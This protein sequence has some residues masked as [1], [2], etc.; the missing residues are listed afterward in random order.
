MLQKE[1]QL[2]Q[3]DPVQRRAMAEELTMILPSVRTKLAARNIPLDF[4]Y[5][6]IYPIWQPDTFHIELLP[7][8]I[9]WVMTQA[10]SDDVQLAQNGLRDDRKHILKA[11][12]AGIKSIQR[13]HILYRQWPAAL[14][15]Q[16]A[17]TSIVVPGIKS[18]QKTDTIL[19]DHPSQYALFKFLA[20]KKLME[21]DLQKWGS[22]EGFV[23]WEYPYGTGQALPDIAQELSISPDRLQ[24]F[25]AWRLDS[26]L[27]DPILVP[28]PLNRY[29][30]TKAFI[31]FLHQDPEEEA[32]LAY[33]IVAPARSP[34]K[35]KGGTFYSIN[36]KVGIQAKLHDSFVDLAYLSGVSLKDL[37][38]F[39]E[40]SPVD[41]PR[42]GTIY[43][44]EEK[45]AKGPIQFHT[46]KPYETIWDV[47][48]QY[49]M[50]TKNILVFNTLRESALAQKGQVLWL[51]QKRPS[52]AEIIIKDVEI[53]EI[54]QN[55][56]MV[57]HEPVLVLPVDTEWPAEEIE[58][59]ELPPL[60][61]RPVERVVP[62]AIQP[63]PVYHVVKKGETV[64][65]L[66]VIYQVSIDQIKDW[67]R[68]R[69]NTIYEGA[70]LLV[71]QK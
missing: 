27:S 34:R 60:P 37:L 61:R 12:E 70:K 25:N 49:G 9:Y 46:L 6:A 1:L 28:L 31:E 69:D 26:S 3:K 11:T 13:D 58:E 23:L 7:A 47:A 35:S 50:Q 8:H 5:L 64:F 39:N 18:W 2:W 22:E 62:V 43:Y 48:H 4:Q 19:L 32:R 20:F 15:A 65:R 36:G 68:L 44:L 71:G 59:E 51:Q 21:R 10:K 30:E 38:K 57:Y 67:N 14:W 56:A 54:L 42:V 45:N 53:P 29:Q 40:V 41:T 33:P 52:R 16:L 63:E 66:S 17:S 55:P 24:A